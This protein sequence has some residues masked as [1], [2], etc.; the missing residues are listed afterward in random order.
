MDWKDVQAKFKDY[1]WKSP[2]LKRRYT[3]L[4][5]STLALVIGILLL[6]KFVQGS[7]PYIWIMLAGI[8][9]IE[10]Y[11]FKIKAQDKKLKS[12]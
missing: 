7:M 5:L 9:G 6:V 11:C 2:A 12:K 10:Y 4:D 8:V 1:N 3:I